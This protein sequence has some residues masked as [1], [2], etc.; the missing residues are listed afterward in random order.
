[1][2]QGRAPRPHPS[3]AAPRRSDDFT[4]MRLD[5]ALLGELDRRLELLDRAGIGNFFDYQRVQP[6]IGLEPM[7][8]PV[9][10]IDDLARGLRDRPGFAA[11]LNRIVRIRRSG[12]KLVHT[13]TSPEQIPES[14]GRGEGRIVLRTTG[15]D[16]T[17]LIGQP[18]TH[19][20]PTAPGH[21]YLAPLNE[22][23]TRFRAAH[24]G[25]PP[26]PGQDED[27]TTTAQLFTQ[28]AQVQAPPTRKII[29]SPPGETPSVLEELFPPLE[30]LEGRGSRSNP[31]A[32]R[33]C[34]SVS[35]TSRSSTGSTG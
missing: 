35:G 2:W 20:L 13:A 24:T 6:N 16:S 19:G 5:D 34:R 11:V 10:A 25:L 23:P 33:P 32:S 4:G 8:M 22:E 3:L 14:V 15:A 1:M 28:R 27:G 12:I 18:W 31:S 7:P 17:E 21:A 26:M 29:L 9:L 30:V